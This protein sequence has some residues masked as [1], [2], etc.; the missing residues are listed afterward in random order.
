MSDVTRVTAVAA[1][2]V[3]LCALGSVLVYLLW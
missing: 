1:K 3:F 2:A